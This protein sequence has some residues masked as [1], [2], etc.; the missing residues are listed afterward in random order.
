MPNEFIGKGTIAS[1]VNTKNP[2]FFSNVSIL[3]IILLFLNLFVLNL[4][5]NLLVPTPVKYPIISPIT[6]PIIKIKA[7]I[8]GLRKNTVA[9]NTGNVGIGTTI[10]VNKEKRNKPKYVYVYEKRFR[11]PKSTMK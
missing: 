1:I 3:D 6:E 10:E 4:F 8:H 11:N 7:A 5:N 2:L 9:A